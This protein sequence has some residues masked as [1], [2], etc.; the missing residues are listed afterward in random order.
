MYY[1]TLFL[2][3]LIF[4]SFLTSFTYRLLKGESFPKGRSYCPNC[5]HQIAWFDNIPLFSYLFLSGA[6]RNCKKPISLSYPAIELS[7]ALIFVLVGYFSLSCT[8]TIISPICV[9]S[10]YLGFLTLPFILLVSCILIAVFIIDM[11]EQ[12]IPDELSFI[13]LAVSFFGILISSS[14]TFWVHVFSGLASALFF[15]ILH[16]ITL[17][18]GMGLGDVKLSFGIGMLL[19]WPYTFTWILLSFVVGALFGLVLISC[20]LARFGKHIA[21]GPFLVISFFVVLFWGNIIMRVFIPYL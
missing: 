17:G 12:L 14:D 15:L 18:R 20:K 16:L 5:N 11:R 1:F 8:I 6:C 3:G 19:G 13:L 21:F 4:G 9:W 2:F 7:T 10:S